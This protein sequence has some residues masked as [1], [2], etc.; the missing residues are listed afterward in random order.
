MYSITVLN[1]N[2][3]FNNLRVGNRA[4]CQNIKTLSIIKREL[5]PKLDFISRILQ[6]KSMKTCL[7][8]DNLEP[9]SWYNVC[10]INKY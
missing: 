3:I 1:N 4:V 2:L 9:I 6:N 10:V 8:E 7:S 5:S